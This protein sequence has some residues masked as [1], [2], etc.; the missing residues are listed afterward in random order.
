MATLLQMSDESATMPD[1]EEIQELVRKA[2][3]YVS[4]VSR[5]TI[6]MCDAYEVLRPHAWGRGKTMD[7]FFTVN[8]LATLVPPTWF[9]TNVLDMAVQTGLTLSKRPLRVPWVSAIQVQR[10][11]RADSTT[12]LTQ[13][14]PFLAFADKFVVLLNV[15]EEHWVV[16]IVQRDGTVLL[17]NPDKNLL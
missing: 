5:G 4:R 15:A 6:A 2:S 7:T 11:L 1:E 14:L 8:G 12:T 9:T 3:A 17:Y 16:A 13:I 10:I